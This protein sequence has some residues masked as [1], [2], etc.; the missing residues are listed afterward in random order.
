VPSDKVHVF[1]ADPAS[2]GAGAT[3]GGESTIG[4]ATAV[5]CGL[6]VKLWRYGAVAAA[7]PGV[8]Q[9]DAG[10]LLPQE[11]AQRLANHIRGA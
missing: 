6:D 11:K 5:R 1:W 8:T 3:L 2:L 7:P 4:L 9:L 10:T